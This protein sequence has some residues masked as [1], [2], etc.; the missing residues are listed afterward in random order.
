MPK[1]IQILKDG[2]LIIGLGDDGVTYTANGETKEWETWVPA[3][4]KTV[5]K[6]GEQFKP[7]K[8]EEVY[9]LMLDK[10]IQPLGAQQ[11]S[12]KFIDHYSSNGWKVGR[13]PM[14][15]WSRA[16]SSWLTRWREQNE[17]RQQPNRSAVERVAAANRLNTDLTPIEQPGHIQPLGFY[18][19]TVRS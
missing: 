18:D 10:G 13:N 2:P 11:Q 9:Q 1:I 4:P 7:P 8:V 3:L 14:K 16:V 12:A 19:E 17:E 5:K 6:R 15:D